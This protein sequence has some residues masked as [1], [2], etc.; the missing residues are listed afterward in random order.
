MASEAGPR[1]LR[2]TDIQNGTV[3]WDS[4]PSCDIAP[5]EVP[6]YRL[7]EGD[8][9]FARTGATTGK[10]FLIRKCP[11]AVFASY[12]IRVR[13]SKDVDPR[14]LALFFQSPDYWRQIEEGKRGIGQPNVNGK[15]LGEIKL[16]LPPLDQQQRVVAEI[17]KQFTQLDAGVASLKRVQAA[18]KRHRASVLK[19]ACEGRLVPTEVEL[20][21]KEN[22]SYETGGQLLQRILAQRREK[23]NGKGK[24]KAPLSPNIADVQSLPE[25]WTCVTIEQ[26]GVIETGNTPPKADAANYGEDIPFVKPPELLDR[27]VSSASDTLS[28]IGSS[29]GRLAP[30]NTV[31]VSC[32]G[33]LGKTGITTRE[34]AFNQQI[35][36]IIPALIESARWIFYAVQENA[37]RRQLESVASATTIAIVNKGKFSSLVIPLPPLAEQTRI[38]AE[39]ERRLSVIEELDAVVNANLF[40]A[41]RLRQSIL[42]VAFGG[43]RHDREKVLLAQLEAEMQN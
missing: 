34:V 37:F 25:G 10:S 23:W 4:V 43:E 41:I 35:N 8:L 36:A 1:F 19:A 6:K 24:Y 33:N 2:I 15:T 39:A 13:V 3:N 38:V 22:R 27:P 14:Y 28:T 18:L 21:S 30:K 31:L 17:E 42:S 7:F 26:L 29:L 20:A 12:L 16:P 11:D 40:R 32:I 9:V 5:E